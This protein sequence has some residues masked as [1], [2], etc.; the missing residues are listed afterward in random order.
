MANTLTLEIITPDAVAYSQAVEMVTLPGVEGQ[1][2]VL[3]MHVPLMTEMVPGE[4]IAQRAGK[5][6]YLAVGGGMIEITAD[7]VAILT[8]MAVAADSID[9][10]KAEEAR[11]RAAA[12]LREKLSD[13][14]VASVNASLAK[15]LAQLRVKRRH[16]A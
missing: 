11:Q 15:S 9:A 2:G 10:A 4:V 1:I 13:E 6:D 3:P 16:R 7:R 8:D 12:R 14:E 5:T